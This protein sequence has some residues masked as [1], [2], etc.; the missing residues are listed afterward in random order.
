MLYIL[1]YLI[2]SCQTQY[3]YLT[4]F[5]DFVYVTRFILGN[6][7]QHCHDHSLFTLFQMCLLGNSIFFSNPKL[8]ILNLNEVHC[9]KI[10]K[11]LE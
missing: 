4:F 1:H 10:N 8:V 5:L 11:V 9:V 6:N 2:N 3:K 7:L